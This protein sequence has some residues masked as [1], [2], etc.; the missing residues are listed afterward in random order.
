M[1]ST[2]VVTD[3][4]PLVTTLGRKRIVNLSQ[5]F[6]RAAKPHRIFRWGRVEGATPPIIVA[7]W[8]E[9]VLSIGGVDAVKLL[10]L[11][12]AQTAREGEGFNLSVFV[13]H[14]DLHAVVIGRKE[15]YLDPHP[16]TRPDRRPGHEPARAT[17]PD[18]HVDTPAV[19]A[20]RPDP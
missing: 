9:E 19:V 4:D 10:P 12:A 1:T 6:E 20:D 18:V 8:S 5:G 14:L 17:G 11:D 7:V 2:F 13:D 16:R 15:K 3:V